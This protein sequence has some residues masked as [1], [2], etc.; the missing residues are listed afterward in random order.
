MESSSSLSQL[1][2]EIRDLRVEV[3]GRRLLDLPALRVRAGERVALIGPNGAGKSTL[4]K[5]LGGVQPASSGYVAV[6][7]REL[8]SSV[9]RIDAAQ[10]RRWRAEVGQL[11]QGLHLVPRLSTLDNVILGALARPGAV[12]L[13]RS[14]L[15]CYPDALIREA[16]S[17]LTNLG[18]AQR[19]ATRA[20][21]LS[22]GER[23]K[24]ALARLHLQCPRL[25]LADEPTSALDPAATLQACDV[26][27]SLTS[28]AT[29]LTVVHEVD[30]LHRLADRVIGLKNGLLAFDVELK[31]LHP[32][33]LDKLYETG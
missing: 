4:L 26:L 10:W 21:Q 27:L 16:Q 9:P 1:A 28:K 19:M 29:L 20:D 14:W 15:R 33:L 23:Q 32:D 24:A 30:L 22:G 25:I 17:A 3:K 5:V 8:G 31:N 18:L 13:W 7:G 6:L 2:I 11:M 12:S